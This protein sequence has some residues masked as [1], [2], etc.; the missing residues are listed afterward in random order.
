MSPLK[1]EMI[2]DGCFLV[3]SDQVSVLFG[4]PSEVLKALDVKDKSFP[5]AFVM[6]SIPYMGEQIQMDPEFPFLKSSF[7]LQRYFQGEKFHIIC[8]EDQKSRL[9][10]ILRS[11]LIG[12]TPEKLW[13]W[14]IPEHVT[15][16]QL[17]I[18][19]FRAIPKDG[20]MAEIPDLVEFHCFKNN[21]VEFE[22]M[23]I[24]QK[25]DNLFIITDKENVIAIDLNFFGP[26]RPPIPF[27]IKDAHTPRAT[28]G[29]KALSKCTTGFDPSGY[30]SG[31]LLMVNSMFL[32]IDGFAWGKTVL[33]KIG[34]NPMEIQAHIITHL[35]GDH[36]QIIDMIIND[37]RVTIIAFR[38][39]FLSFIKKI[40]K[41]LG[42]PE[43]KIRN[44]IDH[45]E[46]MPDKPFYWFGA[47]FDFF[48]T[49]HPVFTMGFQVSHMGKSIV[50]SGDTEWG[51]NLRQC[52]ENGVISQECYD[53][54]YGI[55]FRNADLI[56]M[57]GG[58]GIIHGDPLEMNQA[59]P[60]EQKKKIFLNHCPELPPG[61]TGL[62]TIIP[63]QNFILVPDKK[64][65]LGD[66]NVILD[67][68]IFRGI[69]RRWENTLLSMSTIQ[70]V[71][72]GQSV[73]RQNEPGKDFYLILNGTFS[74]RIDGDEVTQL[75][76]GDF[77]GEISLME[78]VPCTATVKSV[79]GGRVL[80][81][82]RQVFEEIVEKTNVGEQLD[83]I[84][85]IRPLL[86]ECGLV[87]N[88]P[89]SVINEL[90]QEITVKNY[91]AGEV[92]VRQGEKGDRAYLIHSGRAQVYLDYDGFVARDIAILYRNEFF[93][94][95]ALLADTGGTRVAS[96]R[97]IKDTTVF[98][99]QKDAFQRLVEKVPVLYY[100]F[101]IM[102]EERSKEL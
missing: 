72:Q 74:V 10:E 26:Q 7:I 80:A 56:F 53:A 96:V 2:T 68:P 79:T 50:Y 75:A 90:I 19:R 45:V 48:R 85:R 6:S 73:V 31:M 54:V 37:K 98:I 97:A 57:D 34:M 38:E 59:I 36:S 49:V 61:I 8:T 12:E 102:A 55:P 78:N 67:S 70:S 62:R 33:K 100:Q 51:A 95:M 27:G 89:P 28:F 9:S 22:G 76:P 91:K 99:I 83:R 46:V 35:H 29:V 52:L 4:C 58:G 14:G 65:A 25:G 11:I 43:K 21:V 44:M 71:R 47:R 30:T 94:E 101:G 64:M 77:F 93:G 5:D 3:T 81:I 60:D 15:Q 20:Q 84:H 1:T 41:I 18:T 66:I 92:I 16:D 17:R 40:A 69:D 39:I 42:Q 13:A 63:G 23:R 86:L 82:P 88:L 32:M 24:E 87:K